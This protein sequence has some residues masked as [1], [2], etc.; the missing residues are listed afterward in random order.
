MMLQIFHFSFLSFYSTYSCRKN[1][2]IHLAIKRLERFTQN[3]EYKYYLQLDIKSFFLSIHKNIL[4]DKIRESVLKRNPINA[5]RVLYLSNKIIFD[6]PTQKYKFK[7]NRENLKYLPPHKTLFNLPKDKG[8]PI[9]NLTSQFF[10]N[11]YMN[12]FDNFV[13]RQLKVKYY[14]RYVDDMVLLGRSKEELD[15]IK[16]EIVLYLRDNLKLELREQFYQRSVERG[17]DFLG[18]IVRPT[19]TLVRQRV[20][21]NFKYKKAQFLENTFKEGTCSLEDATKFREINASFYGHIKHAD[22][23]RLTKKY[24]VKNWLKENK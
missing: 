6:D 14:M 5:Q 23:D 13:K 4:F 3:R 17:I 12:D 2:G 16:R 11:V 22:S 8:L 15:Y 20:V 21:N 18:Y 19:H 10:A 7:G 24:E 1:R 9:G